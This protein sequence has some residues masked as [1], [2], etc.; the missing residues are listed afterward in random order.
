MLLLPPL[1]RSESN[2]A[3]KWNSEPIFSSYFLFFVF[4][5]FTVRN[6]VRLIATFF[7]NLWRTVSYTRQDSVGH[8]RA[9]ELLKRNSR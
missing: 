8:Q 6:K 7:K 9:G 3:R 1:S 5:S 2:V 4:G